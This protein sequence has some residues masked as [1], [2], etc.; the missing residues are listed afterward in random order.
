[1]SADAWYGLFCYLMGLG[2]GLWAG[3]IVHQR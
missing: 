2:I 1:M 3:C